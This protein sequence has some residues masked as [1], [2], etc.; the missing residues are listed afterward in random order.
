MNNIRGTKGAGSPVTD[1]VVETWGDE[2]ESGNDVAELRRERQGGRPTMGAAP[3]V[4]ASVRLEPE[5]KREL[6]L[7]AAQD[8]TSMSEVIRQALRDYVKAS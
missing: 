8:G 6:M 1:E 7:R 2:A 4:V 5:L 3:A